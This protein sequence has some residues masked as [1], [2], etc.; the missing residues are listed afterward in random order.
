M[1]DSE[2]HPP[3]VVSGQLDWPA[4]TLS[5]SV[6]LMKVACSLDLQK[7]QCL[8][9]SYKVLHPATRK[10]VGFIMTL[11]VLCV[12]TV[13]DSGRKLLELAV[14]T[15]RPLKRYIVTHRGERV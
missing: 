8:C 1:F 9:C 14:A 5:K 10:T 6:T 13:A 3:V 12:G 2:I 4:T 11:L 15:D 7:A